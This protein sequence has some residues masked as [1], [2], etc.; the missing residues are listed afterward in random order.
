MQQQT[1]TTDAP[2]KRIAELEAEIAK[3]A[4][5][6]DDLTVERDGLSRELDEA[7][8][9]VEEHNTEI[10][11]AVRRFLGECERPVGTL[12]YKVPDTPAAQRALLAL[13]DCLGQKL[14]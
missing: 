8:E 13:N 2:E 4:E 1:A 9:A 5:K 14:R 6:V 7:K 10:A 11:D 3:L 12:N